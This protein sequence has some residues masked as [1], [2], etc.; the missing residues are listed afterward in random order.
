MAA[1]DI[2]GSMPWVLEQGQYE[3]EKIIE[4]IFG[5]VLNQAKSGEKPWGSISDEPGAIRK[6]IVETLDEA[7]RETIV[8][9]RSF[10]GQ[11]NKDF[12]FIVNKPC[13]IV[14]TN[15]GD[16][17]ERQKYKMWSCLGGENVVYDGI[18]IGEWKTEAADMSPIESAYKGAGLKFYGEKCHVG[19]RFLFI[20]FNSAACL[21]DAEGVTFKDLLSQFG[22]EDSLPAKCVEKV[23]HKDAMELAEKKKTVEERAKHYG[24]TYGAWA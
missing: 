16:D 18:D 15:Y 4:V 5:E 3:M 6:V 2:E 7:I 14:L 22:A 23:R 12:S 1:K 19:E 21:S 20:S 9:L 17:G 13:Q 11:D 10:P 24:S 8:R